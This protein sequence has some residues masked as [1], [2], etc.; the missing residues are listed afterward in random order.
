M[1]SH[2][3][4][5]DVDF[6]KGKIFVQKLGP[7]AEYP[8]KSEPTDIGYDIT[9]TGRK[10]SRA[11]DTTGEV[12]YFTTEIAVKPPRGYYFELMAKPSLHKHGYTLAT[13]STVVNPND[14]GALLVPL[15]KYSET[16]DLELPFCAVQLVLK[17][18][19][20]AHISSTK[21][22]R[23][24]KADTDRYGTFHSSTGV[25]VP[26]NSSTLYNES[27]NT[28]YRPGIRRAHAATPKHNYMF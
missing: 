19:V 25:Y 1:D 2:T 22:L 6:I 15:Y 8:S 5:P 23:G 7:S 10:D 27:D 3:A 28:A 18:A 12:N 4:A 9:L 24:A 17:P 14:T 11:E 13:G 16:E 26:E 20:Y 21:S